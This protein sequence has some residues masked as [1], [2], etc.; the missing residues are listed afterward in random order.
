MTPMVTRMRLMVLRF[1]VGLQFRLRVG[2]LWFIAA[3][4]WLAVTVMTPA[5][6]AR[7]TR[8]RLTD[9]VNMGFSLW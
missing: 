8:M 7:V 4:A 1:M 6:T 5:V 9:L 2:S 3:L